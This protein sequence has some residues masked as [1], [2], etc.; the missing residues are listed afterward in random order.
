MAGFTRGAVPVAV[1]PRPDALRVGTYPRSRVR[2]SWRAGTQLPWRINYKKYFL[3]S[4]TVYPGVI[5][6]RHTQIENVKRW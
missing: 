6:S 4:I 2:T 3:K 5:Y 1:A